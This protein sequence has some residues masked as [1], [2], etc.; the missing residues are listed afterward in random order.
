MQYKFYLQQSEEQMEG[1]FKPTTPKRLRSIT[2]ERLPVQE[3]MKNGNGASFFNAFR[4]TVK[5]ILVLLLRNY[6]SLVCPANN[7]RVLLFHAL[8][9]SRNTIFILNMDIGMRS[10]R[11]CLSTASAVPFHAIQ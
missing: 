10:Q 2:T 7:G 11:R 9:L 4:Y 3:A 1:Q 5:L 8:T 6:D